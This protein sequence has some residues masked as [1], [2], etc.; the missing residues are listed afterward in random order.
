VLNILSTE[1]KLGKILLIKGSHF[2]KGS[3]AFTLAA[4]MHVSA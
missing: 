3:L 2:D 1:N 4:P